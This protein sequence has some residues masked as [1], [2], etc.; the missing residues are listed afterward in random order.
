VDTVANDLASSAWAAEALKATQAMFAASHAEEIA[1]AW[2]QIAAL[3]ARASRMVCQVH[4]GCL[5]AWET[6]RER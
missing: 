5:E 4:E 1:A 2:A 6:V 3:E